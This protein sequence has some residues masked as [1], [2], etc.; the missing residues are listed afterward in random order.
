MTGITH[1]SLL[2]RSL[3]DALSHSP[4]ALCLLLS[5][6]FSCA[7]SLRATKRKEP[8]KR[9]AIRRGMVLVDPAIKPVAARN[10]EA[11]VLVLHHPTTIKM[12]YQAVI[13]G[14]F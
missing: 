3:S 13:V 4:P 11:E 10:F 14:V 5:L 12:S 9:S 8:L 2:S 6:L 1:H 7:I